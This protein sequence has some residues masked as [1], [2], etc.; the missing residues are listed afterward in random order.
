MLLICLKTYILQIIHILSV[1]YDLSCFLVTLAACLSIA[2]NLHFRKG[3]VPYYKQEVDPEGINT[4]CYSRLRT[5]STVEELIL[6]IWLALYLKTLWF[7]LFF[8]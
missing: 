1:L 4:V 8:S 5:M 6:G 7:F 2:Y 3:F